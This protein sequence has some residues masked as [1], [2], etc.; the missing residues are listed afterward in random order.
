MD[1][2]ALSLEERG[3]L[4]KEGKC[5]HCRKTR[6][7]AKDC[8]NKGDQKKKEELKKKWE[9]KK[10][11]TH[12]R[13]LYQEMD[14]E[15]RRIF[16]TGRED[17]SLKRRAGSMPVSPVL[18]IHSVTVGTIAQNTLCVPLSTVT[19]AKTIE[20]QALID[21]GAGGMYID[22]KFAQNFKILLLNE[23]ITAQNVDGTIK[24]YVELEFKINSRRFRERFYVTG[25]MEEHPDKEENKNRTL[26]LTNEDQNTIL[27]ELIKEDIQIS[28]ITIAMELVAKENR[29]QEEKTNKK[30]IPKEYHEYLD[31]FSEEKAARFPE[32][33]SWDHKIEMKEGF[34]PKSFK[35][36]NFT[37][38]EQLKL[39]KFL[40]EFL[41][42]GY[43]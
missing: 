41:E 38:A 35:N 3:K 1:V 31:V 19:N 14:K 30:L 17:G 42:K 18:D 13:S 36:Y 34:E 43:I 32:S 22:Q 20:T 2:D 26:Y 6:H 27:L 10:L 11:Y 37:Q 12:I 29:K 4:M 33:R 16:E 15:E 21:C 40:K 9:G 5:F 25:T 24:S 7:L 39:D 23:P 28:K 8:P